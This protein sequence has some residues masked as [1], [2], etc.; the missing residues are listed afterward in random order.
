MKRIITIA[1]I[2]LP[3]LLACNKNSGNGG[4][5]ATGVTLSTDRVDLLVGE[6]A[7]ITA[8]VL[9]ESLNMGV[10]WSV[11]DET[12][13]EVNGGVITAKAEGVT[14]VVATSAD[15]SKRAGCMVSVNPELQYSVSIKDETG[16]LLKG[17]YGYP[18]L[19]KTLRATTSDGEPHIFTWSLDD[20]SAG[21]ITNAGVLTLGA[22]ESTDASH[23]YDVQTFLK[24]VT[25]DGCGCKIP[26]RSSLL[27]GLKVGEVFNPVG[28]PV[29]VQASETYPIAVLYE[30]EMGP[31]EIPADVVSFELSNNDDFTVEEDEGEYI[32]STGPDTG[33]ST[34][35]NV[36]LSGLS[37]KV[38]VA[39]LKID[40]VYGITAQFAGASSSTLTFTW[41]E[42]VS[43]ED[44]IAKP[45][46]I[47]LYKDE[48][49]TD[50]E[51]SFSIPASDGCWSGRQPKFVLSGLAPDTQYW[52]QVLDTSSGAVKDSPVIP[53]TTLAF[54]N[55][56][57]SSDPANEGDIIL[58]EDFGQLCWGADEITQAAGYDVASSS[59]SYNA[60][61]AC[62]F[63]NRTAERFV[64]TTGEYA[65]RSMTANKTGKK[66]AGFRL[67]HWAI[68]YYARSYVGPGY[69][70]LS[71][72]RYSTHIIT[73]KLE[74]IP[75]GMT[76]KLKVTV[77]A[78]GKVS[79]GK[80][81]F[82][83]QHGIS[84]YEISSDNET[85]KNKLNLTSNVQSI[86]YSGGL[87]NLEEFEVTIDGVV[88]GDRIAFGPEAEL[89]ETDKNM[90]LISDMT[91]QIVE[92]TE[93]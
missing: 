84:F 88:K 32:L 92:L 9:P 75:E 5:G 41:T 58:A 15:G 1:I 59:T 76:A 2:L 72:Y 47:S 17:I 33:V 63:L 40:K 28:T 29:I 35:V 13:A 4:E 43:P 85:N 26:V 24:V 46:K 3:V 23:I 56:Q 68:G 91:V 10:V 78:A 54:N 31:V 12:Y 48:E 62:S 37:G 52:F 64:G 50:L 19:S 44:D 6:T 89:L 14:Y 80:A 69:L 16:L 38:A 57:V 18:G 73:P 8:T 51:V 61:L 70:F 55:I 42:G 81:V 7:T 22:P 74:S 71:T 77:H 30:D 79:G 25:E 39:Q 93:E 21:T 66:E 53:A 20:E 90:M 86:T 27:A 36:G 65:Q 11:I 87:T 83:V 82:A 49:C 60:N 67:A 34:S 45:Y